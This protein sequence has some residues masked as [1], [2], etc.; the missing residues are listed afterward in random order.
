VP[1]DNSPADAGKTEPL[2]PTDAI[3]RLHRE[4]WLAADCM[5]A[6][7][8]L[9]ADLDRVQASS[10]V[11]RIGYEDFLPNQFTGA[12]P[13]LSV[14]I[15]PHHYALRRLDK[16]FNGL[17]PSLIRAPSC[18]T[19][20]FHSHKLIAGTAPARLSCARKAVDQQVQPGAFKALCFAAMGLG[21]ADVARRLAWSDKTTKART[22][23]AVK[24]LRQHYRDEDRRPEFAHWDAVEA[25]G[26]HQGDRFLST[27]G[28][29]LTPDGQ[30]IVQRCATTTLSLRPSLAL[31]RVPFLK[32]AEAAE[33][34]NHP[35]VVARCRGTNIL[36]E[37]AAQRLRQEIR[38]I[39]IATELWA[40]RGR[41]IDRAGRERLARDL[42][43]DAIG[44]HLPILNDPAARELACERQQF[45]ARCRWL[46]SP[47]VATRIFDHKKVSNEINGLTSEKTLAK[48]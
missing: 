38:D 35:E 2:V 27:P 36:P 44:A 34:A 41:A 24:A 16:Q 40:Q 31:G 32:M 4:G 11:T 10:D 6:V 46:P 3:E 43:A 12:E 8:R 1:F 29:R 33:L 22:I 21:W 42:L 23:L 17:D 18:S 14:E 30:E 15:D 48:C 47:G 45:V 25:I 37:T 26:Q 20:P 13:P 9:R 19:A 7:R 28:W 39:L 5:S